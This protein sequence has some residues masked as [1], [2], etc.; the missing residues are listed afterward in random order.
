[1]LVSDVDVCRDDM[2]VEESGFAKKR[3]KVEIRKMVTRAAIRA[4][5]VLFDVAVGYMMATFLL[6]RTG[7]N[8]ELYV[9][10]D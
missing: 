7:T 4:L 1:M 2:E 8:N 10:E 3:P 9:H 5:R 6:Y